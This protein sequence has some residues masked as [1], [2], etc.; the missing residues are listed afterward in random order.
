MASQSPPVPEELKHIAPYLQRSLELAQREPVVSYY[1]KY[2]A[3]KLAI[4]K[5]TKSK[6]GKSFALA[7]MDTLEQEKK[8]L[9]NSEALS[10]D[11]VGFAHVE[12]FALKIFLNADNED[13][14]GKASKQVSTY[15]TTN[16]SRFPT[17]HKFRKTAKTFLA[18]SLFLEL[19]RT[20][21]ELDGEIEEKIKYSKY[22]AADIMKA[23]REGRVPEAGPP[24]GEQQDPE[25]APDPTG[26]QDT[27]G[28]SDPTGMPDSFGQPI[29]SHTLEHQPSNASF[30]STSY[31]TPQEQPGGSFAPPQMPGPYGSTPTSPTFPSPPSLLP[32]GYNNNNSNPY[33][34]PP[35]TSYNQPPPPNDASYNSRPVDPWNQSPPMPS[36]PQQPNNQSYGNNN[37]SNYNPTPSAPSDPW[38]Q[39]ARP[40]TRPASAPLD[41]GSGASTLSD[42]FQMDH[43]AIQNA[44]KMAKFAISA[45]QYDDVNSAIE[46]L[47]KALFLLKPL[48]K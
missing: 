20:F 32:T 42:A 23:L 47:E 5:G 29:S 26:P 31:G 11:V 39:A 34:P 45:L 38:A 7:L 40:A 9:S 12:N 10:N 25:G 13:R 17:P 16:I 2:Y 4:E 46:N 24:G 8:Q 44:Q 3:V 19:L 21:G 6:E 18:A 37:N 35:A 28:Q 27:F 14:A 43:K 30:A 15:F 41:P 22:K 48:K 33:L 36:R 1:C